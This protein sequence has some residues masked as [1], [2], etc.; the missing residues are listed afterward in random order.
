VARIFVAERHWEGCAGL[1]LTDEIRVTIAGQVGLLMLGL[2]IDDLGRSKTVLVYPGEFRAPF[3]ELL[4]S[5]EVIEGVDD[6]LGQT[7]FGGPVA[8]AWDEVRAAGRGESDGVNPV[9]HEFAHQLDFLDGS[10]N[11]TPLLADAAL[12]S[13]WKHVMTAAFETHCR[14]V[15]RGRDTLIDPYGATNEG[16]FFAVVTEAFFEL[17]L[18]LSRRHGELYELFRA[19]YRQDPARWGNGIER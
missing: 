16:E 19:Y 7:Q 11:G 9:I 17:P 14:A 2:D 8:I 18:D 5:G 12:D 3:R 6:L 1:Q 15:E 13:R 4:D 10:L